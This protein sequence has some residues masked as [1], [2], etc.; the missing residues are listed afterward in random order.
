MPSTKKVVLLCEDKLHEAAVCRFLKRRHALG[1]RDL[2]TV[3]LPSGR[4]SGAAHVIRAVADEVGRIRARA[5]RAKCL[6]VIV[7]DDDGKDRGAELKAACPLAPD[8]P[9]LALVPKRT[10]ATWLRYADGQQVEEA[11]RYEEW[12][13]RGNESACHPA[14]DSLAERCRSG[15]PLDD[16][17]PSLLAA[18]EQ[19]NAMKD[20]IPD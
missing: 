16:A 2:Y 8:D 10:L 7:L 19:Y 9:V 18:C 12:T 14:V 6:L 4:G 3:D 11:T 20:R 17:P 15:K 13:T 5:K 1:D